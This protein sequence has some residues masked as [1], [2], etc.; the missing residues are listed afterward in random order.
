MTEMSQTSSPRFYTQSHRPNIQCSSQHAFGGGILGSP[1]LYKDPQLLDSE[2]RLSL[3]WS[4]GVNV[5]HDV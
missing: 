4:D 1:M 3:C 2:I 5:Y